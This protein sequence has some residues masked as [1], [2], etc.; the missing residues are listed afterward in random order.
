MVCHGFQGAFQ[1][2]K[3]VSRSS[4]G[5]S[6]DFRCIPRVSKVFQEISRR[7]RGVPKDFKSVSE[8]CK[9]F[10][11]YSGGIMEAFQEFHGY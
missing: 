1:S 9:E 8:F 2:L 4:S 7:S 5:V 10:Q 11:E 3:G 6:G